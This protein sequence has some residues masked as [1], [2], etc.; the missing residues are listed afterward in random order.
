MI[1]K[2]EKNEPHS[3]P[4]CDEEVKAAELPWCVDCGVSSRTCSN[5]N[6][7]VSGADG[8]CKNCGADQNASS[9]ESKV[10]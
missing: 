3:C 8:I 10:D 5:C 6:Q 9:G 1:G 4:Y 7:P 2:S